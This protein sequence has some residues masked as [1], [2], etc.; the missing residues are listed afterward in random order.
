MSNRD[1]A[2]LSSDAP[3]RTLS[4]AVVRHPAALPFFRDGSGF[5]PVEDGQRGAV[6]RD[7][8]PLGATP[9]LG[10]RGPRKHD[11]T[12]VIA[13]VQTLARAN[14]VISCR[15]SRGSQE[16]GAA[17]RSASPADPRGA[18]QSAQTQHGRG[19]RNPQL[20]SHRGVFMTTP[21]S[22]GFEGFLSSRLQVISKLICSP[23]IY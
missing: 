17:G 21:C 11:T 20:S 3:S 13:R 18:V 14:T 2:E 15:P 9:R 19:L 5:S 8:L 1:G 7:R 10:P 12:T 6:R 4:R 22:P 16:V 23:V